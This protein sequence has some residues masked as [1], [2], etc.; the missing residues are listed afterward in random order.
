MNN[1]IFVFALM[2]S[3]SCLAQIT[4]NSDEEIIAFINSNQSS[5]TAGVNFRGQDESDLLPLFNGV[6]GLHPDPNFVIPQVFH[7]TSKMYLPATFDARTN[8][9]ECADIIGNILNQ[10]QCGSCWA[11]ATS[12]VMSDRLCIQ[13]KARVKVQLSPQDLITCCSTCGSKCNG[14]YPSTAFRYWDMTGIVSGGDYLSNSGCKPYG[15]TEFKD[16]VATECQKTCTNPSYKTPYDKDKRFGTTYYQVG[17]VA[18][19]IQAEIFAKGSV[20][21]VFTV[22]EDFS[23]YKTGVYYHAYGAIRG[24]HSVKIIGWGVDNGLPYWLVANS[25]GKK[26]G[27]LGGFFKILRGYN[28]CGIE[29]QILG[30]NAR[31]YFKNTEISEKSETKECITPSSA[32]KHS[33]R[34][35]LFLTVSFFLISGFP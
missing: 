10:G 1:I 11:F 30:A 18:S 7:D 12:E 14:G 35:L 27:G 25:W 22:Y 4:F 9:P 34:A 3:P 28:H 6:L 23:F 8:W 21:A 24:R 33:G 16:G 13:N 5:W 26:W 31:I 17:V 15:A 20:T 19:Q 29:Q 32:V 2:L